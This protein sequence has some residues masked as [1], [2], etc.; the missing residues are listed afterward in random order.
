MITFLQRF[1]RHT[2]LVDIRMTQKKNSN[3]RLQIF[4]F[5]LSLNRP[6]V[7]FRI[8]FK[9]HVRELKKKIFSKNLRLFLTMCSYQWSA[10]V[11]YAA[12]FCSK[13]QNPTIAITWPNLRQSSVTILR[14]R[15]TR[16]RRE[17]PTNR[18]RS[19]EQLR[20]DKL[21]ETDNRLFAL[22]SRTRFTLPAVAVFISRCSETPY[23]VPVPVPQKAQGC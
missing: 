5:L 11:E 22:G 8:A 14:P 9:N 4:R 16:L 15:Q 19:S 10:R 1:L 7:N 17:S 2:L 13:H 12:V 23:I 20:A 3:L 18:V 6:K 21:V